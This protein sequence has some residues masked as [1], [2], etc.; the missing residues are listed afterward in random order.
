MVYL[1]IE[2]GDGIAVRDKNKPRA[3]ELL[4]S[5]QAQFPGNTLFLR[6]ITRLQAV[7]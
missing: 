5:L 4:T 3:I 6:E 1:G 7:H 2:R